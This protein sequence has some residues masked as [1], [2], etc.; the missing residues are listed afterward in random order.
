[1]TKPWE[2][3]KGRICELV[4]QGHSLAEIRKLLVAEHRFDAS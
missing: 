2:S 1:M 4:A 3:V